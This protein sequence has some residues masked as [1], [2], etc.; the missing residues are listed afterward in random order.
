MH[1]IPTVIITGASRGIGEQVAYQAAQKGFA[2]ILGARHIDRLETIACRC[3]K[4][5]ASQVVI[6]Y[7]DLLDADSIDHFIERAL[8][9]TPAIDVLVNNAGVGDLS[10][11]T[12][13]NLVQ[14][15]KMMKVNTLG[16][17]YLT[18]KIAIQMIN[19]RKGKIIT[20]ASLAGKVPSPNMA[21]YGASKAALISFQNS[22]RIE[23]KPYNI[24]VTTINTGPVKTEFFDAFDPERNYLKTMDLFALTPEQVAHKII[25]S[26]E[27]NY[28]EIN[29]PR[30]LGTLAHFTTLFPHVTDWIYSY[31]IHFRTTQN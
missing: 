8:D 12:S 15:I 16:T 18:Q 28:R 2:L 17:M 5:G 4:L 10:P 14:G 3:K 30:S 20:V 1:A 29:I 6:E 9:V 7:L 21:F 19:Q 11:F 23:L 22:I 13:M 24:Q 31:L 27:K 26:I 25:D